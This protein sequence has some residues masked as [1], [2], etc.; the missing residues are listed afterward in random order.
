[1]K[2]HPPADSAQPGHFAD[3]RERGSAG[4]FS[5]RDKI[6]DK[7]AIAGELADVT[8]YLLQLASVC[9]ID[10]EEAV[11]TKLKTNYDRSWDQK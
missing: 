11:L 4:T 7:Q 8:L 5:W 3:S 2:N 1:M 10:L 6:A 9:E